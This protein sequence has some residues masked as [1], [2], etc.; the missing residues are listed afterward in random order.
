MKLPWNSKR[1]GCPTCGGNNPRL[2]LRCH[3]TTRLCDWPEDA[4]FDKDNLEPKEARD[5]AE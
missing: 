4:Y 2:C 3:G 5:D 1:K